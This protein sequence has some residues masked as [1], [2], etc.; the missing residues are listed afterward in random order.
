MGCSRRSRIPAIAGPVLAVA[1]RLAGETCPPLPP[2]SGPVVTVST[3]PALVAA[4]N[5]ATAGQTILVAPGIYDLDGA[6]LRIA[7][8]GVTL[9]GQGGDREAV[10][11]DGNSLTTEIVQVVA[12][13]VTVADL[14][15]REAYDHPIHV[16]PSAAAATNGTLV[17]NVH[18]VDP[19]QQAIKVNPLVPGGPYA[20]GGTVACSHIEMTDA[21][22]ARVRDDCYTGGVDVHAGRGW[23]VRDNVIEGFWCPSGLSEH[24]VHFWKESRDTVVERN[25]LRDD[26]RGVGFGL[27]ASGTV[28]RT[29]TDAPCPAAGGAYVDHY[30]GVARNNVVSAHDSRLF[31]SE[32][33][34]DCG[35][36]LWQAC[37]VQAL[38]NTIWS[39]DPASSFSSV[40]WR[41][42]RT[43]AAV[44]NNLVNVPLRERDGAMA[45]LAGNVTGAAAAWFAGA[46]SGDLHLAPSASSAIDQGVVTGVTDDL[47][48]E[49]RPRG[50]GADVGADETGPLAPPAPSRFFT[51]APCRRVDTRAVGLGGPSPLA[52]GSL[53]RFALA[54]PPCGVPVTARAVALNVTATAPTAAGHLRLFPAGGAEPLAS[55]LNYTPGLTRA[56]NAV[57]G[58]GGAG[59]IAVRV[60]Q[61]SGTVHVVVDVNG[62]FE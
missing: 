27:L 25:V 49:P 7:A 35:V 1:A 59:E 30:G 57:V 19:G 43:S 50:A 3:V 20:D 60:G 52:A 11:L 46:A 41:F 29:W 47:D 55:T 45:T 24:A 9:R 14:T 4:V 17:H 23:T 18:V 22:R 58:L 2:P 54:G 21:G 16:M 26:A 61:P 51:V 31:A 37:G 40:E 10:V 6:Y 42:A 12:S 36:C 34:F 13:N 33:G 56:N 15:L 5:G 39:G 32:F 53:T 62:Y 44:T 38:H 8:P 28:A 48:G